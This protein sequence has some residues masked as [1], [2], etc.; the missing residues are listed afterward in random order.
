VP[1]F[2]A[3]HHTPSSSGLLLSTLALGSLIGA[4]AYG[5]KTWRATIPRRLL[6]STTALAISFI[7]LATLAHS[8]VAL[9]LILALA[10]IALSPT[11]TTVFIAVQHTASQATLTE[12]FTWASLAATA[13]AAAGQALA[14]ALIAGPG[15]TTAFW[16]PATSSAAA[17]ALSLFATG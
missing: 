12:A 14:G 13:G 4:L 2:S 9:A 1:G 10:G 17:V 11:L 16:L 5:A 7:A 6:A 8:I 3:A 15:L